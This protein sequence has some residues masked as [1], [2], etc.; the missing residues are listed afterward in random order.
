MPN[1]TFCLV[2]KSFGNRGKAEATYLLMVRE[3]GQRPLEIGG[4]LVD[5]GCL[6]IR[7]AFYNSYFAS[8]LDD[9]IEQAFPGGHR[10]ESAAWGRKLVEDAFAYGKSLGFKPARDYKKAARV[11]GGVRAADC[12]EVFHFGKD[13][14]PF[15]VQSSQHSDAEARRIIEHLTR[16]LGAD[17][18]HFIA[19]VSTAQSESIDDRV[20]YYLDKFDAG[21]I[22]KAKTGLDELA[23]EFPDNSYVCFGQGVVQ[24]HEKDYEAALRFFNRAV[25][26]DPEFAEAWSNKASAHAELDEGVD[27]IHALRK[28]LELASPDDEI[29]ASAEELLTNFADS[30]RKLTGLDLDAYLE[31]E[32]LFNKACDHIQDEEYDHAIRLI[33]ENP[34]R[35]PTN[36]RTLTLLALCYRNQGK[37]DLAREALEKAL[38][39]DPDHETAQTNLMLLEAE[40]QGIGYKEI[41]EK[42]IEE[43]KA[44]AEADPSS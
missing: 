13:G 36:E 19:K 5:T 33:T 24:M 23:E 30:V 16:R 14:K 10:E 18:F 35:L 1:R 38:E 28:V 8:E 25:E 12:E 37:F 20:D 41:I 44:K 39:M 9:L 3:R 43:L 11:F 27:M 42:K 4:F 31:A 15:Y 40:E 7:D 34:E 32:E 22:K 17:G 29:H 6:G 21:G 26:L 2:E